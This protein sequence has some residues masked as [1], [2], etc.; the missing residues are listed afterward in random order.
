MF[1]SEISHHAA[2]SKSISRSNLCLVVRFDLTFMAAPPR[3]SWFLSFLNYLLKY[4]TLKSSFAISGCSQVSVIANTSYSD[5]SAIRMSILFLN[6]W[7]FMCKTFV[8]LFSILSVVYCSLG[9]VLP[10]TICLFFDC[11]FFMLI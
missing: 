10:F 7:A 2:S 6:L 9:H 11:N 8:V 1:P 5:N 4:G 3:A